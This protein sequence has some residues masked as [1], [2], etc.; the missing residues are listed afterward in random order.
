M[1]LY[2]VPIL[3]SLYPY[4][5]GTKSFHVMSLCHIYIRQNGTKKTRKKMAKLK[6]GDFFFI[7]K[8][9]TPV[10]LVESVENYELCMRRCL[11]CSSNK[12]VTHSTIAFTRVNR[13]DAIANDYVCFVA[14]IDYC[15]K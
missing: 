8:S 2:L 13:S 7:Q 15:V 14:P 9:Y 6:N 1:M 12:S 11:L 5:I 10:H 3:G 4:Q